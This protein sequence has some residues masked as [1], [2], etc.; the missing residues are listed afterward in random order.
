MQSFP[1][2]REF[3]S[4]QRAEVAIPKEANNGSWLVDVPELD[5]NCFLVD[6]LG[7]WLAHPKIWSA[8]PLPKRSPVRKSNLQDEDE[9]RLGYVYFIQSIHVLFCIKPCLTPSITISQ[10]SGCSAIAHCAIDTKHNWYSYT[11]KII[12]TTLMAFDTAFL[13]HVGMMGL[14]KGLEKARNKNT[15]TQILWCWGG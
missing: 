10:C 3:L 12:P 11:K 8:C 13:S 1:E 6:D 5:E 9:E 2:T 14:C 4:V 15:L 7:Y